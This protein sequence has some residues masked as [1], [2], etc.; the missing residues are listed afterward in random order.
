[1]LG[2]SIIAPKRLFVENWSTVSTNVTTL[3][4]TVVL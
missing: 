1:M 3:Y 2:F 4:R